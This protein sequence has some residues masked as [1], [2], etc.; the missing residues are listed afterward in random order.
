MCFLTFFMSFSILPC[1][2]CTTNFNFFVHHKQFSPQKDTLVR[3]IV[4]FY[5]LKML[6]LC[7]ILYFK[8]Y[9]IPFCC[10]RQN[11][12]EKSNFDPVIFCRESAPLPAAN[13]KRK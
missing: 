12:K 8:E 2:V 1:F 4:Q 13:I 6:F 5:V 10:F 11:N 3:I 7:V 9:L